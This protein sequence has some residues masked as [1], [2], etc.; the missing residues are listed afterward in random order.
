[1]TILNKHK[2][3]KEISNNLDEM[4]YHGTAIAKNDIE[5]TNIK[6]DVGGII[7]AYLPLENI[8]A[9]FFGKDKWITFHNT[10]EEFLELFTIIYEDK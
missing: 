8:F 1:M 9:V 2:L 7:T 6:K 10:E 4:L 5:N 3:A